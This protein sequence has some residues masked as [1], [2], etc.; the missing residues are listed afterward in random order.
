MAKLALMVPRASRAKT[1]AKARARLKVKSAVSAAAATVMAATAAN[2]MAN[3]A[4]TATA[5]PAILLHRRK[6][7]LPLRP[8][9]PRKASLR[10][11][12]RHLPSQWPGRWNWTH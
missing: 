6:V 3:H 4:R 1:V 8:E 11:V 5:S 2:A 7:A 10:P 12:H 9:N